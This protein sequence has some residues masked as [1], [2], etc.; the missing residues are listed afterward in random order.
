MAI[1]AK[2]IPELD[3]WNFCKG[4]SPSDWIY[5]E[6]RADHALGFCAMLWPEVS[7]FE[8][9]VLREPINV[10]H[11]RGW[12]NAGR[13]RT[14][15]E[16]AMNAYFLDNIFPG[17][18]AQPELK[19]AQLA[20]LAQNMVEMLTAKLTTRFPDRTFSAFVIDDGEDFAVSFHQV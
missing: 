2:L 9:Y 16:T 14:Q 18:V 11:L 17:D 13:D 3:L 19:E 15:I 10:E 1:T 4:I 7:I 6:G 8:R 20:R 5:G 12:E